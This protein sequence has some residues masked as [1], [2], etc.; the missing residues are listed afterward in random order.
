MRGIQERTARGKCTYKRH[1][2]HE[3]S[4]TQEHK[5]ASKR[6]E[7]I[8]Y[9]DQH[10]QEEEAGPMALSE[11]ARKW[12]TESGMEGLLRIVDAPPHVD[13]D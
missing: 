8:S 6:T 9:N 1:R 12:L 2:F 4:L 11:E 13:P 10:I 3:C 5:R 7:R